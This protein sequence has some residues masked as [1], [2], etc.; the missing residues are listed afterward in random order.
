M[1]VSVQAYAVQSLKQNVG[2]IVA[3][4]GNQLEGQNLLT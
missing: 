1:S 3:S 4:T 2:C